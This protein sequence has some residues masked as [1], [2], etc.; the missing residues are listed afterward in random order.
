MTR[1]VIDLLLCNMPDSPW[2]HEQDLKVRGHQSFHNLK[3]AIPLILWGRWFQMELWSWTERYFGWRCRHC[4]N[5]KVDLWTVSHIGIKTDY[6]AGHLISIIY[7]YTNIAFIPFASTTAN[8]YYKHA[9][10][11]A[12]QPVFSC[13]KLHYLCNRNVY[14]KFCF[15]V[16]SAIEQLISLSW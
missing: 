10:G 15:Q 9:N 12:Y 2:K 11:D 13:T 16:C 14:Q 6:S 3:H 8:T 4:W 5:I 7:H 1:C